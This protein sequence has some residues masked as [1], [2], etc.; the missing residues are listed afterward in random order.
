[1][2]GASNNPRINRLFQHS[3]DDFVVNFAI[4]SRVDTRSLMLIIIIIIILLY[5]G[6]RNNQREIL[7]ISIRRMIAWKV[8]LTSSYTESCF[9]S[10]SE[11]HQMMHMCIVHRK[12]VTN[13][14]VEY[15]IRVHASAPCDCYCGM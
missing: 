3:G 10:Q 11:G 2:Q 12:M 13:Y 5:V 1:M 8:H 9:Y 15:M 14:G 4:Y 7:H 6:L